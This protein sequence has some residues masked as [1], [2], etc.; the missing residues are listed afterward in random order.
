MIHDE[1]GLGIQ[2]LPG[3]D[4]VYALPSTSEKGY[5]D[6]QVTVKSQGG[7]SSVPPKHTGIGIMAEVIHAL[8]AHPHAPG[9]SPDNPL[10][11]WMFCLLDDPSVDQRTKKMIRDAATGQS[12]RTRLAEY[13]VK[14][15]PMVRPLLTTTQAADVIQGG[16]K[17][18]ALPESTSLIVNHRIALHSNIADLKEHLT[19]VLSTL[20]KK[21]EVPLFAFEDDVKKSEHGIYVEALNPLDVAPVSP[22][23]SNAW[24]TVKLHCSVNG[25]AH[26]LTIEQF[27]GAIRHVFGE[28][29]VVAPSIM[30]G[31]PIK[32]M[33]RL[34]LMH[35]LT[36][37]YRHER[38]PQC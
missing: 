15:F 5:L 31:R 4:R 20:S 8:E 13:L 1:G 9:L 17:A 23:D 25:A 19:K 2:P 35:C 34:I 3:G 29:V 24:V 18:N 26:K 14:T 12:K 21:L 11:A 28:D 16:V 33:T 36:R 30:T 38:V 10:L 27:S 7:H 32:F 22:L 6:V 37:Q